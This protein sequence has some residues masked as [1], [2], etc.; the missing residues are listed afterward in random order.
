MQ[1]QLAFELA[2]P[3]A[4]IALVTDYDCWKDDELHVCSSVT[5]NV[6][7][8]VGLKIFNPLVKCI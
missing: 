1:A 5:Y 3:Y 4:S 7:L 6:R 2:L 8:L